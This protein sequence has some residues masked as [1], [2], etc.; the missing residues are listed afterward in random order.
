[1]RSNNKLS[2][3]LVIC[4]LAGINA[5]AGELSIDY[6]KDRTV[7][8]GGIIYENEIRTVAMV[9]DSVKNDTRC[10]SEPHLHSYVYKGVEDGNIKVDHQEW[11]DAS[12]IKKP[13]VNVLKL[14]V[15]NGE[16]VLKANNFPVAPTFNIKLLK[17][18]RQ[19]LVHK[20]SRQK[21]FYGLLG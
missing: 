9:K 15:K 13:Q 19:I 14:P 10:I 18:N 20:L 6:T 7:S 5:Y 21:R 17:D 4:M 8:I 1:M 12:K 2:F 3:F 11:A 16:A